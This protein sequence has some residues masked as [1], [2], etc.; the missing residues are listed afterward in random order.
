MKIIL[1][2]PRIKT[3]I[4]LIYQDRPKEHMR[5]YTEHTFQSRMVRNY[6]TDIAGLPKVR[7]AKLN[8]AYAHVS[9]VR[10]FI[11]DILVLGA[12]CIT[13]FP[14]YIKTIAVHYNSDLSEHITI[15]IRIT[16]GPFY[17]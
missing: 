10:K 15:D 12:L 3:V 5:Y 16:L 17:A 4:S 6:C 1:S 13:L 7:Q 14:K 11:S 8:K 2:K 9:K